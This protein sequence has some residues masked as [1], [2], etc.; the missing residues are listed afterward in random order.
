MC[1]AFRYVPWYIR[2]MPACHELAQL[3][4]PLQAENIAAHLAGR[5]AGRCFLTRGSSGVGSSSSSS[6]MVG[7]TV[8]NPAAFGARLSLEHASFSKPVLR[9]CPLQY[10]CQQRAGQQTIRALQLARH[11]ADRLGL[12]GG[13]E[14][15]R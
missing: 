5:A 8:Y 3:L 9:A 11:L 2:H 7:R 15:W 1:H 12:A 6:P 10:T 14:G 4:R 13:T